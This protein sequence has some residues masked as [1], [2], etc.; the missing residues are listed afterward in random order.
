MLDE[1]LSMKI[2]ILLPRSLNTILE[3]ICDNSERTK[4]NLI[5]FLI[6]KS[7]N[8]SREEAIQR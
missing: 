5:R 2:T 7:L 3:Q 4:S 6:Y 1:R 8:M